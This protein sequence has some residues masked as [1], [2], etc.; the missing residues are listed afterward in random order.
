MFTLGGTE[1]LLLGVLVLLLFGPEKVPQLARTLG[2]AMREF[3]KYK[4]IME[5]AFRVEMQAA[6][7]AAS[8]D[9]SADDSLERLE[10]SAA[11][12]RE[13][14]AEQGALDPASEGA[15]GSADAS[16]EEPTPAPDMAL[17]V[18]DEDEEEG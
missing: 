12:S 3:N 1:L 8:P 4:D 13:Y 7:K 5:S 18:T 9:A 14:A 17:T 6:E 11:A 16:G 2:R 10:R 15:E